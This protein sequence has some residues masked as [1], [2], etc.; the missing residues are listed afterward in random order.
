M[1]YTEN[2][3]DPILENRMAIFFAIIYKVVFIALTIK[4]LI[5][6]MQ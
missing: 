1:K 2:Y 6:L 3:S 5:W 4:A